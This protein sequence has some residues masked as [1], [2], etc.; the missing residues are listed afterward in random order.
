M[1]ISSR[2][3]ASGNPEN[4][5]FYATSF[6][7]KSHGILKAGYDR[8]NP[9][10]Y[11]SSDEEV[12]TGDLT[13]A[14]QDE[15]QEVNAPSWYKH[16]WATE[17]VHVHHATLK[18]KNRKRLDI[19]IIK[20]QTGKRPILRFEAKRLRT[21][22]DVGK[23]LGSSGLGCFLEGSYGA[24]N[25]VVG[26]IGYVQRG[27]TVVHARS[28]ESMLSDNPDEYGIDGTPVWKPQVIADGLETYR[29]RHLRESL[30]SADVLHT[31]LNFC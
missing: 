21:H 1:A 3:S 14:M 25:D 2:R 20:S 13:K 29:S 28:I 10:A 5:R 30:P 27:A 22:A 8:M 15:L 18:G 6:I 24:D 23:Y 11:A 12:I 17:E 7:R 9:F 26:M 31:M 4:R 19:E 16:F